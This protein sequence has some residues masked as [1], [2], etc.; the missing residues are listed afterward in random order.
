MRIVGASSVIVLC[1]WEKISDL[2]RAR[3]GRGR[4]AQVAS[5]RSAA[6]RPPRLFPFGSSDTAARANTQLNRDQPISRISMLLSLSLISVSVLFN[7]PVADTAK[8][9]VHALA[10]YDY[11][12][13][14]R[15][16][17]AVTTLTQWRSLSEL[18]WI[19]AAVTLFLCT[20]TNDATPTMR[21][22]NQ[23]ILHF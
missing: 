3:I 11:D 15:S 16:R 4:N 1:D 10:F 7:S 18:N 20:K 13:F 9:I 14:Q 22:R 12:F 17:P 8:T 21:M 19:A 23:F 5:E 2:L 6:K